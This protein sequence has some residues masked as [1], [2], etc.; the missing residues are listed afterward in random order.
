MSSDGVLSLG[1]AIPSRPE[2]FPTNQSLIAPFWTSYDY[3]QSGQVYY[4][5][6]DNE[7]DLSQASRL[8][9]A[10]VGRTVT[11]ESVVVVTWNE[12]VGIRAG[13]QVRMDGIRD[14]NVTLVAAG[15]GFGMGCP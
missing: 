9:G 5:E 4:R 13:N 14:R 7:T 15:P 12:M 6:S 11:A 2:G 8:L 1:Q 3:S 10:A